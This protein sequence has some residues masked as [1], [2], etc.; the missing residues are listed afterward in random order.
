MKVSANSLGPVRAV[1][2]AAVLIAAMATGD[3]TKADEQPSPNSPATAQVK[4]FKI[5]V[6]ESVLLDLDN[7]LAQT[8][9]PDQISGSD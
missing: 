2:Y 4:P 7:R 1:P 8:R 5:A 9:W 6:E 3:P